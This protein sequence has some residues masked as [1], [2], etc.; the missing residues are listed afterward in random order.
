MEIVLFLTIIGL[1][2][3]IIWNL[4]NTIF[5][6]RQNKRTKTIILKLPMKKRLFNDLYALGKDIIERMEIMETQER[7]NHTSY[8]FKIKEKDGNGY[9]DDNKQKFL[10]T[11]FGNKQEGLYEI[12]DYKKIKV[13]GVFRAIDLRESL[14]PFDFRYPN[15]RLPENTNEI[16]KDFLRRIRID[17]KDNGVKIKESGFLIKMK[18]RFQKAKQDK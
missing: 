17:A 4:I 15:D 18:E 1:I 12:C 3:S 11:K 5:N 6:M 7:E 14:G 10:I 13:K 2:L 16:K 9:L 8:Q